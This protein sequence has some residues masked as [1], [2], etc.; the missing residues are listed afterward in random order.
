M[1]KWLRRR[2]ANPLSPVRIRVPPPARADAEGRSPENDQQEEA[3]SRLAAR[4]VVCA[5]RADVCRAR[6]AEPVDALDLKSGGAKAP[7]G[8][9]T[10]PGHHA[11]VGRRF[12]T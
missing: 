3:G 4:F 10:L 6:V 11:R 12:G 8:F 9:E 1:A 2:I 5:A 7:W